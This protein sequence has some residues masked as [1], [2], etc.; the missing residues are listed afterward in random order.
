MGEVVQTVAI[1]AA[2]IGI[3]FVIGGPAG[4]ALAAANVAFGLIQQALAPEPPDVPRFSAGTQTRMIRQPITA[5]RHVYGELRVGGPLVF[6]ESTD[7]NLN[8]HLVMVLA[9]SEIEAVGECLLDEK[10]LGLRAG[11][12]VVGEGFYAGSFVRVRSKLGTAAQTAFDELVSETTAGNTARGRGRALLYLR[13]TYDRAVFPGQ[14]PGASA[15]VRGRQIY[16]PRD[17]GTRWSNNAALV[18]RD[19]LTADFGVGAPSSAIDDD[20]I[21]AAANVC[22][23]IVATQALD[24]AVEDVDTTNDELV[25]SGRRL[26]YQRGDRVEILTDDTGSP[27]EVPGGL[28]VETDYYA[29]PVFWRKS[30]DGEIKPRLQLA[31]S[32]A[33]ARAG[34]AIDLTSAGASAYTIRKTGE[35]RYTADGVIETERE[36]AKVIEEL[37]TALAGTLTYVGGVWRLRGGAWAAPSVTFTEADMIE[38]VTVTSRH[39]RRERF[40][41]VKGVYASPENDDQPS[42]YP[43]VTSSVYESQDGGARVWGELNLPFT[44]RAHM[45]Q[46]LAKIKLERHRQQ[47]SV[48]HR[49]TLTGLQ[50]EAGETYQLTLDRLGWSA[51]AFEATEWRLE[52]VGGGEDAPPFLSTYV[53]GRETAS[54]VFDWASGEETAVDPAPDTALPDPFTVAPPTG[55]VVQTDTFTLAGGTQ[56]DRLRITWTA[57]ADIYVTEGG[58]IE[59]Q[60]RRAGQSPEAAWEPAGRVDGADTRAFIPAVEDGAA[61]DVRVRSVNRLNIP[62]DWQQIDGYTIGDAAEGAVTGEDWGSIAVAADSPTVDWGAITTAADSPTTDWGSIA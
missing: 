45:A 24:T 28:A 1:S 47:I 5:H 44:R 50:I 54:T 2:Q 19:Y 22:D 30:A 10:P 48:G 14:V 18:V 41:A 52:P 6:I 3:G 32:L 35:P 4:A 29:I 46:R 25:L 40:N 34:T 36:P 37:L 53:A 38:P 57:P 60:H 12:G 27:P 31:T 39:S 49:M 15:I 33:N 56:I 23:E 20:F 11:D 21:S 13:L 42:D 55:L 16:D 26:A 61:Y 51:K 59:I 62:S 43:P 17:G 8:L 58:T 7:N 9:A